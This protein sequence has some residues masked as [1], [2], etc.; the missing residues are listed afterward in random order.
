M[1]KNTKKMDRTW[2]KTNTDMKIKK[3]ASSQVLAAE[4]WVKCD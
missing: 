2:N 4:P 1:A 3:V